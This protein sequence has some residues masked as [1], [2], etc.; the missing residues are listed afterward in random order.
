MVEDAHVSLFCVIQHNKMLRASCF[1]IVFNSV[2]DAAEERLELMRLKIR[3]TRMSLAQS[4]ISH[5]KDLTT[6]QNTFWRNITQPGVDWI[7]CSHVFLCHFREAQILDPWNFR[8]LCDV[9]FLY[10][11]LTAHQLPWA[12]EHSNL[13]FTWPKEKYAPLFS[14]QGLF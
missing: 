13:C 9:L 11:S 6:K 4:R 2:F 7:C 14:T 10:L 3:C 8:C 1:F 5:T 12:Y